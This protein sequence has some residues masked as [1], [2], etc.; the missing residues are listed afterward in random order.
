MP[1]QISANL[2]W[3]REGLEEPEYYKKILADLAKQPA[4]KIDWKTVAKTAA[5]FIAPQEMGVALGYESLAE[6][7]RHAGSLE[8]SAAKQAE[9]ASRAATAQQ[10]TKKLM[11]GMMV[12]Q[13]GTEYMKQ[14]AIGEKA[15]L[16]KRKFATE[17]VAKF[18]AEESISTNRKNAIVD[19]IKKATTTEGK[20]GLDMSVMFAPDKDKDGNIRGFQ[21]KDPEFIIKKEEKEFK[22]WQI[23]HTAKMN[24]L[25]IVGKTIQ[26]RLEEQRIVMQKLLIDMEK[27]EQPLKEKKLEIDLKTAQARLITESKK[28]PEF[29]AIMKAGAS[30]TAT[31]QQKK[32]AE[33]TS[34]RKLEEMGFE[35][36]PGFIETTLKFWEQYF[37]EK[38][39][40]KLTVAKNPKESIRQSYFNA[41]GV[42]PKRVY[43]KGGQW[44]IVTEEGVEIKASRK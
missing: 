8:I 37:S 19:F 41:K 18:A 40:P 33:E 35:V 36:K 7:K 16:D 22:E 5:I 24:E 17:F 44:Y 6:Q 42:Y 2:P 38:I 15:I 21:V 13:K 30:K 26:N 20:E 29:E 39:T 43:Q 32:L 27:A 3:E 34:K 1:G 28:D 31:K 25:E 14:V 11:Q 4:A 9:A 10:E 12:I 23:R